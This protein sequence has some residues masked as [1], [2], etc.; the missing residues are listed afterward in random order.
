LKRRR[1]FTIFV[2]GLLTVTAVVIISNFIRE[3]HTKLLNSSTVRPT[4]E[5][6]ASVR[7]EEGTSL[8]ISLTE[9]AATASG[10]S[11][12]LVGGLTADGKASDR[13]FSYDPEK[14][15]W[16]ELA[17]LPIP[18][19]HVAV[20]GNEKYIFVVG[21]YDNIWQPQNTVFAYK[22][23]SDSWEDFQNLS[24]PVAAGT[25]QLIG[26]ELHVFGGVRDGKALNDH[27]VIK[28][29]E[30]VIAKG[31]PMHIAREHLA[32]AILGD[33]IYVVGGRV[34]ESGRMRNLGVLEI[35]DII[36]SEWVMGPEMPTPRSGIAA[37][38]LND[39]VFVLGGESQEK[40]YGEVEV[41]D[42]KSRT[43]HLITM[44]PTPRHGLG[45]AVVGKRIFTIA[46][47]PKPG[48]YVSNLNEVLVIGDG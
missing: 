13:F 3:V 18:L 43:W 22:I 28:L 39:K 36:S 47:G 44:M 7:W 15:L 19:H 35:Y 42:V 46:G 11:I 48:L 10:K 20:A 27:I 21:G 40:T 33:R 4:T 16:K 34:V 2:G 23:S 41:F 32:S 30:G 8:P 12:Y 26:N 38:S 5:A 17:N 29:D 6:L 37:V 25:C 45:A 24:N 14:R 9:V 1:A 31:K